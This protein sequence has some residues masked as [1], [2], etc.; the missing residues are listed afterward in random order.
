MYRCVLT[1]V[2]YTNKCKWNNLESLYSS[3]SN[4]SKIVQD[5]TAVTLIG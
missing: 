2:F 4:N 5:K 3:T 1:T